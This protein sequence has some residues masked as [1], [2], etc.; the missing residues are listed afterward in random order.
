MGNKSWSLCIGEAD[1]A[2]SQF[3]FFCFGPYDW[4]AYGRWQTRAIQYHGEFYML[5][6]FL[7]LSS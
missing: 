2:G 3:C 1:K 4:G 7:F 6:Q 5:Y